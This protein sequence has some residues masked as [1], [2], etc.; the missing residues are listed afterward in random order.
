MLRSY[1]Y[2]KT[3]NEHFCHHGKDCL[4]TF[5]KT[6]KGQENKIINTEQKPMDPIT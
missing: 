2:D 5:S 3:L 6:L 4:S 1:A